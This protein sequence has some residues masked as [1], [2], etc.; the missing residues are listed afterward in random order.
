MTAGPSSL[1]PVGRDRLV[2]RCGEIDRDTGW[3]YR[4]NDR[5]QSSPPVVSVNDVSITVIDQD[6]RHVYQPGLLFV[7]F[8]LPDLDS[9][10][11]RRHRQ[12]H[13]DIVFPHAA[14]QSGSQHLRHR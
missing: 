2:W 13:E 6:N 5:C 1:P 3:W 11:R 7:P 10:V 9:I 12:L 8:G 4:R 14:I